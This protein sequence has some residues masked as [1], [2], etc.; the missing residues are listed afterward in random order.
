LKVG[1][2]ES[3]KDNKVVTL[4]EPPLECDI[5]DS[6]PEARDRMDTWNGSSF[7]NLSKRLGLRPKPRLLSPPERGRMAGKGK[8]KNEIYLK[9]NTLS[10]IQY[11][12]ATMNFLF[13]LIRVHSW[14]NVYF[15]FF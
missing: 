4:R 12:L 13:E 9:R 14:L 15:M 5:V 8:S 11:F 7:G 1:W 3:R 6:V 2:P 10:W